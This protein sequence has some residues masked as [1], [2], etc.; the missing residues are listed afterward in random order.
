MRTR[1]FI[2]NA[3]NRGAAIML[4]LWALFL[5]S[6]MIISW[7]LDIDTRLA[8]AGNANRSLEATAM[9]CSGAEV[10]MH[11]FVKAGM[12]VLHGGFPQN[13]GYEARIT[14]E[15]GRLNLNKLSVGENPMNRELLRK[16]LET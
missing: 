15:G 4:A 3:K 10:A 12:P 13:Q 14:G 9:A 11:P 1:R 2:A 5:L 16:Y 6:A 7:A 8:N